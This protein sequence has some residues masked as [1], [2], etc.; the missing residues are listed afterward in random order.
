MAKHMFSDNLQLEKK[1]NLKSLYQGDEII[2]NMYPT[3]PNKYSCLSIMY[4]H[5]ESGKSL[6]PSCEQLWLMK[7]ELES[8]EF[9]QYFSVMLDTE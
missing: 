9:L 7:T 8:T 5:S 1:H 6:Y 2:I 4:L 3:K